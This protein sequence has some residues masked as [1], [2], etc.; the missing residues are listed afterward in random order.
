MKANLDGSNCTFDY[1]FDQIHQVMELQIGEVKKQS[2]INANKTMTDM[3]NCKLFRYLVRNVTFKA[4][5]LIIAEGAR[6][7]GQNKCGC[8]LW[9]THGL[10][11]NCRLLQ[12]MSCGQSI[13]LDNIDIYWRTLNIDF[14]RGTTTR[15]KLFKDTEDVTAPP[16]VEKNKK[17]PS[18]DRELS[19]WEKWY[20]VVGLKSSKNPKGKGRVAAT[21]AYQDIPPETHHRYS[22]SEEIWTNSPERNQHRASF[23]HGPRPLSPNSPPSSFS[24]SQQVSPRYSSVRQSESRVALRGSKMEKYFPPYIRE[25][26]ESYTDVV[27]DG[28]CGFRV[29]ALAVLGDEDQWR[30]IRSDMLGDL[31]ERREL[32][33]NVIGGLTTMSSLDQTINHFDGPCSPANY[34]SVPDCGYVAATTYNIFIMTFGET[35]GYL[36]PP[37]AL[38]P[39]RALPSARVVL[40]HVNNYNHWIL[41]RKKLV[42][43]II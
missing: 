6:D 3:I 31:R 17:P 7:L 10:P 5:E 36:C 28:N 33:D 20:K 37:V 13:P 14:S 18:T 30:T 19:N 23:S 42:V 43:L 32:Y 40:G 11:C 16:A 38:K 8:Y 25:Y 29:V 22:T 21:N 2:M 24:N 1:V 9:R 35:G 15:K 39:Y 26:I 27:G 12:Y 41:V 4:F 34:F